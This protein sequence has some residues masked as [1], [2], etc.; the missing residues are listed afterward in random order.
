M[1]P[2][3]VKSTNNIANVRI[4]VDQAINRIK[5]YRVLKTQQP[6]FFLSMMDDIIQLCGALVNL[7]QPL[8]GD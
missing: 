6:L 5:E 4:Y 2:D 1:T 7:K 3:D 8:C